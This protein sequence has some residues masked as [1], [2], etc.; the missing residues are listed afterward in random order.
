MGKSLH[1]LNFPVLTSSFRPLFDLPDAVQADPDAAAPVCIKCTPAGGW[2]RDRA[3]LLGGLCSAAQLS[4]R[5]LGIG[6]CSARA[7][8]HTCQSPQC[9]VSGPARLRQDAH[10]AARPCLCASGWLGRR[11]AGRLGCGLAPTCGQDD[12]LAPPLQ[13]GRQAGSGRQGRMSQAPPAEQEARWSRRAV[14]GWHTA[15]RWAITQPSPPRS[16]NPAHLPPVL[17]VN[18]EAVCLGDAPAIAQHCKGKPSDPELPSLLTT[19]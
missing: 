6:S 3:V 12:L 19:D 4:G 13:A 5:L 17:S 11:G 14:L 9:R 7:C 2:A 16:Y 10:S 8:T 18:R 15:Q 1:R